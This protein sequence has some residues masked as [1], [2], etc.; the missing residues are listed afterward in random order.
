MSSPT[1]EDW[2]DLL[3][4]DS[5]D[6]VSSVGS[7]AE[8]DSDYLCDFQELDNR[9]DTSSP[10]YSAPF[11][12]ECIEDCRS[13]STT[14][15]LFELWNHGTPDSL[16][17]PSE[18]AAL[19]DPIAI[20]DAPDKHQKILQRLAARHYK[21]LGI[22]ALLIVLQVLVPTQSAFQSGPRFGSDLIHD[23]STCD[24]QAQQEY[25]LKSKLESTKR[26][27]ETEPIHLLDSLH[28]FTSHSPILEHESFNQDRLK[29]ITSDATRNDTPRH[30]SNIPRFFRRS[31]RRGSRI[32][33]ERKY[34]AVKSVPEKSLTLANTDDFTL[35][36]FAPV[37]EPSTLF[38]PT[39]ALRPHFLL[40]SKRRFAARPRV[41][42]QASPF[43]TS[44]SNKPAPYYGSRVFRGGNRSLQVRQ[45]SQLMVPMNQT[46][47]D[48][49]IHGKVPSRSTDIIL[50]ASHSMSR[51]SPVILNVIIDDE[52]LIK[53][54]TF[55]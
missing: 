45:S 39:K 1:E 3:E 9:E 16:P 46:R 10:E 52:S 6:R 27:R 13:F 54:A 11:A 32:S 31:G 50:Q 53:S 48:M 24:A 41:S 26:R 36:Q 15:A 38:E 33:S 12:S 35:N 28:P 17:R 8:S 2:E 19:F 4:D 40:T 44:L 37:L 5:W 42:I 23:D 21:P 29:G 18:F 43:P 22:F 55:L 34:A 7:D 14:A 30:L 25:F 51:L 20:Q 47:V 49:S